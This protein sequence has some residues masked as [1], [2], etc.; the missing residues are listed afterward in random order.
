MN[1]SPYHAPFTSAHTR[2]TVVK[3]LLIA[4]AVVTGIYLLA[5]TLSLAFPP[6]SAGQ[7]PG[8]NPV[9]VLVTLAIFL[10]A[11]LSLIIYIPTVISFCVWLYRA[12]DNLRA[13]NQWN[14][15][16]YS[17]GWAV[18][19][20]FVPFVNLVVPYRAVRETWQKSRTAE[21]AQLAT[22]DPPAS[23]PIWW[24]F[25]LLACFVG[26]ISM[27][28]S[29][30][31]RVPE[32]TATILSIIASGLSIVAAVF[33]YVVVDTVD[34][35]QEETSQ[36]LKLGAFPVP[37]PPPANLPPSDAG[38]PVLTNDSQSEVQA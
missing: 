23:F 27:R 11:V 17:P 29:F 34:K 19:S 32:S 26:N 28:A 12:S 2:A 1:P 16:E 22:P 10:L 25:W 13:F 8:D 30:N 24:T 37:P 20:F 38:V 21:E 4:G 3:I 35:Q 7:E 14:R 15:P 6:L 31:E 36:K 5:E 33:A 9:G 18:G